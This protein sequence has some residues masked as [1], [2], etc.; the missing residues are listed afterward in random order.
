MSKPILFTLEEESKHIAAKIQ[1]KEK[2]EEVY[3]S[4]H[5]DQK[6][7]Q[8]QKAAQTKRAHRKDVKIRRKQARKNR[9][10]KKK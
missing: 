10:G 7:Q 6:Y 4:K 2:Q 9:M 5:H 1:E 3:K 8:R